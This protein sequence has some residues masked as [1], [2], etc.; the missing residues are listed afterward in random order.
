MGKAVQTLQ[1]LKTNRLAMLAVMSSMWICVEYRLVFILLNVECY[2]QI[3]MR[4]ENDL[5]ASMDDN[6]VYIY[7]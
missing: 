7:T 1:S 4:F 3:M 6:E 5:L 2:L